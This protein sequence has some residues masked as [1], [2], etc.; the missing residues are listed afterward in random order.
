[1][2]PLAKKECLMSDNL[3]IKELEL[4]TILVE[5][6]AEG[7]VE[8]DALRVKVGSQ[9]AEL[10]RP[11]I[12][13]YNLGLV[14]ERLARPNIIRWFFGAHETVYVGLTDK[15]RRLAIELLSE[16]KG[17]A[18]AV[19][20]LGNRPIEPPPP[21]SSDCP[22]S[23]NAQHSSS[24][25]SST[26]S[27]SNLRCVVAPCTLRLPSTEYIE[28]LGGA[29]LETDG[30]MRHTNQLDGLAELIG[31]LGF[32]LTSAGR[33]L[34]ASRWAEGCSDVE[35]SLEIV[36]AS[37]AHAARLKL[38]ST[39]DLDMDAVVQ[40]IE[41]IR[42]VFRPFV[43]ENMLDEQHLTSAMTMMRGVVVGAVALTEIEHYLADPLRGFA[44]PAICPENIFL[45]VNV[46]EDGAAVLHS[47]LNAA[48]TR[49][50]SG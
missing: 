9:G 32:E 6:L 41:A 36:T 12:R 11:Y 34:A 46:D 21:L 47:T 35:V 33:F 10:G 39:T 13:L 25:N 49:F 26:S 15:G 1:M 31:L 29:P 17:P 48:P 27:V 37:L 43:R 24:F 20:P 28:T 45:L 30:P 50:S 3:D 18:P 40:L 4:F 5:L 42:G 23:G 22:R 16:A 38:T 14:S 44:P 8:Q 7:E 19:K 2:L